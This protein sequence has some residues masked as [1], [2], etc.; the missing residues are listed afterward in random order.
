MEN[1]EKES[2]GFVLGIK[3]Y[4]D[5]ATEPRII[6]RDINMPRDIVINQLRNLTK[7]LEEDYYPDFKNNITRIGMGPE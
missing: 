7:M 4:G 1:K 5:K 3:L 6:I 2:I